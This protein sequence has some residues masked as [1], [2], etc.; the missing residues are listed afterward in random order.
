MEKQAW[1]DRLSGNAKAGLPGAVLHLLLDH[2]PKQWARLPKW[3]QEQIRLVMW[4][5]GVG[6]DAMSK[7]DFRDIREYFIEMEKN[8]KTRLKRTK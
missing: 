5:C 1:E 6:V 2:M 8:P 4:H 7:R 3:Y